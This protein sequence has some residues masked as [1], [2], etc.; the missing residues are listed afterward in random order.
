[1]IRKGAVWGSAVELT[2]GEP[3]A[4][5]D[6]ELASILDRRPGITVRLDGGDLFTSLGGAPI[7]PD[8][9]TIS[10]PI[11][12]L[13][14]VATRPDGS[15]VTAVGVAHAVARSRYWSGTFA[16][17]MGA[18]QFGPWNLG[19]K[20]HPNDG[21]VDLTV[22]SLSWG[23][24]LKARRL[25]PAGAHVPHPA[26]RTERRR[27]VEVVFDRPRSLSID[28]VPFGRIVSL[29]VTA[30]PDAGAVVLTVPAT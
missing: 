10:L 20:A 14:V 28:A 22:G 26:L 9:A 6:A 24:R 8:A 3:I 18:T 16:V 2:G 17:A 15:V 29:R 25:A 12:L 11:D 23:D 7:D 5:G 1:M 30:R 13:D 27:S 19:P 4:H 21:L